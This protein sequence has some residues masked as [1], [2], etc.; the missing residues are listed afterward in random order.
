MDIPEAIQDLCNLKIHRKRRIWQ[1][2]MEKYN[3]QIIGEIGVFNGLNFMRMTAHKPRIAVAIDSW[4]EDGNPA[5]NDSAFTLEEKEAQYQEFRAWSIDKPFVH[6]YR[7]YSFDA[8]H[9]FPD[10]YFDL[11]YIDA[12][13]T[14][15]GCRQDLE[16]WYPKVKTGRFFTGDDYREARASRTAVEFGVVRAVNEFAHKI[17]QQ[18][19]EMPRHGW[20]IIK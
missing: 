4:T 14:Y 20:V 1:P 8:F 15:E 13:H 18:I 19:Y 5:H 7:E 17:N 10:E 11:L 6:I 2:F 16:A 3:C 9:H 12:D